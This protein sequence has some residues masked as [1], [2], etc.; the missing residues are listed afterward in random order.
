MRISRV[1]VR[2]YRCLADIDLQFDDYG[3]LIGANG[4]GKS[5][6]LYALD[7]FFN[8]SPLAESDVHGFQE[9][10][11]LSAAAKIEVAVTFTDLTAK[12]R[13]RLQQY[14]RGDVAEVRRTWDPGTKNTKTVGNAKQGPGF[15]EI[16]ALTRV[17]EF[18]P[19]YAELRGILPDL[20]DLGVSPNKDDVTA[21]LND[22]ERKPENVGRLVEIADED[23]N[24]MLGWNGSNV[25]RDCVRFILVPA[26]SSI[27]DQVGETDKKSALSELIGVFMSAASARAQADWLARHAEDLE[28][29]TRDIRLSVEAAT[30]IQT[31][32][33]N[34]RLASLVP[35]AQVTLTPSVPAWTPKANPSITTAVT[36]D[37]VSN[38]V[39]RQGHGVQRAV[40]I[41]MFQAMV[42]DADLTRT[43]HVASEGESQKEAD[44]RLEEAIASLPSVI[45]SIEEPEIYQHPIR[46]RAFARTLADLSEQSKVQVVLATHSPYFLRPEQFIALRRFTLSGG[47]SVVAQASVPSVASASGISSPDV[48]RAI[49]AN[50][51]TEFSEGFFADVVVLTEGPTDRSVLSA[52]AARLDHDL[53]SLGITIQPVGKGGLRVATAILTALG[54]PVY[55]LADGDY[56]GARRKHPTDSAKESRAHASHRS[57]TEQIVSALPA[58]TSISGGSTPYCFGDASLVTSKYAIWR[59]DIEEELLS[60]SSFN[61]EL[62]TVGVNL[63]TRSNKNPLAYRNAVGVA[64]ISELPPILRYVIDAIIAA[65][66]QP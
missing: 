53:D 39:S 9:G 4:S 7:W 62:Q 15:A 47:R 21:A 1:R 66:N 37:G 60:W 11:P 34:S 45:V 48:E 54:V 28:E 30:G 10:V 35:N 49:L 43:S 3:V 52:V 59:D 44:A 12:D 13:E 32:R 40:M 63:A 55:V 41:S 31:G 17:G 64:D 36:I 18:R 16:R 56:L 51:Q 46:A 20:A 2:G 26:A 57:Q 14:G 19:K 33:V 58:S 61:A 23:A 27:T 6:V 8:N 24:Q 29:L 65:K 42:P 22:W 50:L 5:S 38:D 25:I